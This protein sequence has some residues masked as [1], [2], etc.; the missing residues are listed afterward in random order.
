MVWVEHS[1]WNQPLDTDET[2]L[3]ET[4]ALNSDE[5]ITET[6]TYDHNW[7]A[8]GTVVSSLDPVRG[9]KT[10]YTFYY[11]PADR[12]TNSRDMS[13]YESLLHQYRLDDPGLAHIGKIIHDIEVNVFW[14]D[15]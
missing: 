4:T 10:D 3:P 2:I 8:S 15:L 11:R 7:M 5:I 13:T 9:F 12:P 6:F 14:P 1:R